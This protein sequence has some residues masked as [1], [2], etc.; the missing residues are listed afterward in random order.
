MTL[1]R[2]VIDLMEYGPNKG[3]YTGKMTFA[4]EHG[5][6]QINVSPEACAKMFPLV[7]EGIIGTAR[8]IAEKLTAECIATSPPATL[9]IG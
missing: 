7:S 6:V 4:G 3:Q 8:E 9:K 2:L 1:K 5:D